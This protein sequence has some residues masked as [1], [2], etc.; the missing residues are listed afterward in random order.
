MT[1]STTPPAPARSPE[2]VARFRELLAFIVDGLFAI[3]VDV[4]QAYLDELRIK[5]AIQEPLTPSEVR[6]VFAI[7]GL[8]WADRIIA[9]GCVKDP[10]EADGRPRA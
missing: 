3:P 8:D 9:S 10:T 7:Q 4:R 2:D 1:E 5:A 6:V